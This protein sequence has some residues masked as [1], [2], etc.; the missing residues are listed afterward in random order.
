[1]LLVS[2]ALTEGGICLGKLFSGICVRVLVSPSSS[3]VSL[4]MSMDTT[5]PPL[6]PVSMAL[7][8]I[9]TA[10]LCLLITA[11]ASFGHPLIACIVPSVCPHSRHAGDVAFFI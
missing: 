8:I 11:V 1:W 9:V 3:W 5:S 2:E 10:L 6:A 4:L 7:V